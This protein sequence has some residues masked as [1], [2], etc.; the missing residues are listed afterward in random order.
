M[1]ENSTC[2][3]TNGVCGTCI[4]GYQDDYCN[5]TCDEH[6]YGPGCRNKC[7][8]NCLSSRCN[9][10]S[11]HCLTCITQYR[12]QFCETAI[13]GDTSN[14]TGIAVSIAVILFLCLVVAVIL[15]LFRRR[16]RN[17]GK[18]AY[19]RNGS[20]RDCIHTDYPTQSSQAMPM[21]P[22]AVINAYNYD[23]AE[24][25]NKFVQISE[26]KNFLQTHKSEFFINEF[27][28]I[29][30][31]QNVSMSIGQS[32]EHKSKNRY[33]NICAYD[34]SR[35]HLEININN[36]E[37]DYINASYIE[38]YNSAE[39]CIASQ[40]PTDVSINDFIRMLWEQKV[41]KVVMLTELVE[42]GKVKCVRYWP[43]E[44]TTTFGDIKVKLAATHVFADY[45]IRKLELIKKNQPTHHF[46][47]FHF[48]SWPDKGVP[49]TP[50]GLV[51][52]EQR[53]ALG[54][55][56]RP[57]VV[58]CSA[59]VG[60]TGTFI[61]LRNVMREAEDTGKINCFKTVAK[62]R[63]DRVLMVQ[64]AK[65]YEFLYK[66]AHVAMV[67][68]GTTVKSSAITNR[69]SFLGDQSRDGISNMEKEFM[70]VSEACDDSTHNNYTEND[71]DQK[72]IY[73]NTVSTA[74][75]K[76][77]FSFIL[78]SKQYRAVLSMES[79]NLSDYINA[80]LVSSF[81]KREN[82]I[83][84]QLPM[85]STVTDFWRLVAQYNVSLI[86]AFNKGS[87]KNDETLPQYLPA[88]M[89]TPLDCGPY[90]IHTGPVKSESLWEEQQITVK[91]V[92]KAMVFLPE[93]VTEET[94]VTHIASKSTDLN[95]K[96]LLKLLKHTRSNNVQAQ[97]RVLYMCRNGADY[98]GLA[99]VLSLLLDRMD[100]D[101]SLTVPLVV[102]AIKCIRPQVIPSLDQYRCLYEVLQRY[103]E[104]STPHG[105]YK[106]MS[107]PSQQ[108]SP[109]A[110][111]PEEEE[112]I[113]VNS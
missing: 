65:Q 45:T 19:Q 60:R 93:G 47:Q 78:P 96:N 53:V 15:L 33:K 35:V 42:E 57:I 72:G 77:R 88:N 17:R 92:K 87:N 84:T 89:T 86:L 75:R 36:N 68:L 56:S 44:G 3:K 109:L 67:C 95:P 37:R 4:S 81:T 52:F 24:I 105:D 90:E 58:H 69:I 110:T 13:E 73:Q 54:S 103:I 61:A 48:T 12:G 18:S 76:N 99:C 27:K 112:H 10:T 14:T 30:A 83:L 113:Y 43:E 34:H 25:E 80:V 50:W 28:S 26:L 21:K 22:V 82:Q 46:T 23:S 101:Q 107:L 38:G 79:N 64:T 74:L 1:C 97:G 100:H 94:H 2:D 29:P 8:P 49:L 40:G 9:H 111:L 5:S 66:A 102:G 16:Y 71:D 39:K 108:N 59:G 7:S 11:G 41:V 98:S 20:E 91:V 6:H 106:R 85:P 55:T 31:P 104:I 51:D 63:Q 70:A 62:L 32:N